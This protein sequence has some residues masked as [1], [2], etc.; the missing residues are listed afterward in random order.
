MYYNP[1]LKSY[2]NQEIKQLVKNTL[3]KFT[4]EDHQIGLKVLNGEKS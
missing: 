3:P 4:Y 2:S 1:E